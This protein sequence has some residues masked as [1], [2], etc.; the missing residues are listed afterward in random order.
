MCLKPLHISLSLHKPIKALS[1]FSSS[2]SYSRHA[3]QN[4]FNLRWQQIIQRQILHF[5]RLVFFSPLP[6]SIKIPARMLRIEVWKGSRYLPVPPHLAQ[7]T[8]VYC[9]HQLLA[10]NIQAMRCH[11]RYWLHCETE[12]KLREYS[13]T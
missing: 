12:V 10:K 3:L 7:N 8:D 5:W 11:G 4:I 13:L 6:H 1:S 9:A 2:P